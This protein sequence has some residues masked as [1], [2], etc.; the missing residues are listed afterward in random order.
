MAVADDKF[1]R[2]ESLFRKTL[3]LYLLGLGLRNLLKTRTWSDRCLTAATLAAVWQRFGSNWERCHCGSGWAALWTAIT[4]ARKTL[5][6]RSLKIA[7]VWESCCSISEKTLDFFI[8]A[9]FIWISSN[10]SIWS[11]T[12]K[13]SNTQIKPLKDSRN[14]QLIG[15]MG[16]KNIYNKWPIKYPQTYLLL[17]LEQNRKQKLETKPK[18]NK[19]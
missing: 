7:A 5:R 9:L 6:R 18:K 14:K 13:H 15:G 17:A 19:S 10:I 1:P 4:S 12:W 11:I 16:I 3:Y 2:R 8:T